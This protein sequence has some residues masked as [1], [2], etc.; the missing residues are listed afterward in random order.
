MRLCRAPPAG[1]SAVPRD[2][3]ITGRGIFG[4]SRQKSAPPGVPGERRRRT[5]EFL[6]AAA[7]P[8]GPLLAFSVG[9]LQVFRAAVLSIVLTLAVGQNAALLCSVWCH[10]PEAAA[11]ACEHQHQAPSPGVTANDSCTPLV[12]EATAFVREDVR[13]GASAPA[14]QYGAAPAW[15][16]F[17]PPPAHSSSG[18]QL[19]QQTPLRA[20]RLILPLRI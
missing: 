10:P 18:R 20:S 6:R 15:F 9:E 5:P 19:R 12:A 16:Q 1:S 13:R 17:A 4:A 11:N 3:L 8:A 14:A 2:V 7:P